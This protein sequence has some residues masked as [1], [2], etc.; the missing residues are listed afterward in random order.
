M[1]K[2]KPARKKKSA[3]KPARPKK[4]VILKKKLAPAKS[5]AKKK[6]ARLKR[7]SSSR[8]PAEVTN[9]TFEPNRRGLGPG[10]GGQSGDNQGL[11]RKE[12]ADSESVEELSEEGQEYEAEVISGVENARDPDQGE[13]TTKEV[14]EDDVPSE[15]DDQDQ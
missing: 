9:A 11:S 13:V 8:K 12:S 7:K 15:Y 2:K 1:A 5:A 10:A 3:K 4:K 6:P 14:P